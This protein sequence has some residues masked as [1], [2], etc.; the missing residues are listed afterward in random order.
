MQELFILG[1]FLSTIQNDRL[2]FTLESNRLTVCLFAAV[3]KRVVHR[4]PPIKVAPSG[5]KTSVQTHLRSSSVNPATRGRD[6]NSPLTRKNGSSHPVTDTA[7]DRFWHPSCTSVYK[8]FFR[9]KRETARVLSDGREA[10]NFS[11]NAILFRA[12]AYMT[13]EGWNV[14]LRDS[15][16]ARCWHTWCPCM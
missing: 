2:W 8:V 7:L 15:W 9:G 5:F 13:T 1:L 6:T 14:S 3:R 11:P 16:L 12:I 4:F 10:S